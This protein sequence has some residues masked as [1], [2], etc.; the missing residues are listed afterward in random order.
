MVLVIRR[1][2]CFCS[3]KVNNAAK[4]HSRTPN[5]A[6]VFVLAAANAVTHECCLRFLLCLCRSSMKSN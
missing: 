4:D 1:D 2:D 5:P 6:A 3:L